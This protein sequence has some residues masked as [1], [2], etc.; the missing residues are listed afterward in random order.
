VI[1]KVRIE[2]ADE[3]VFRVTDAFLHELFSRV[4]DP[5][6]KQLDPIA[7]RSS[8]SRPWSAGAT[9]WRA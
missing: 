4:R 1:W 2:G 5:I 3:L 8:I 6:V 9:S 7:I